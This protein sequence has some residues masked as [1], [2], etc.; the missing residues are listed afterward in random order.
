MD[1]LVE[2]TWYMVIQDPPMSLQFIN[3]GEKMDEKVF[4]PYSRTGNIALVCVWPALTLHSGGPIV[5]KG[6]A[7]PQ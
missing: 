5:S 1:S 4:K 3:N 2:L 7:L 6:F